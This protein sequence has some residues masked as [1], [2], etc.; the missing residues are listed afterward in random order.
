MI[1]V[2]L[3]KGRLFSGDKDKLIYCDIVTLTISLYYRILIA[4]R[5]NVE[6]VLVYF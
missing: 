6:N 1:F 3:N 2:K 4:K 5:N